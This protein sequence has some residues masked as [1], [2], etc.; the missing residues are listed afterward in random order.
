M[1]RKDR[2]GPLEGMAIWVKNFASKSGVQLASFCRWIGRL[3]EMSGQNE[4]VK[5][6]T[7]RLLENAGKYMYWKL[8][9]QW[10]SL[11]MSG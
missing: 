7:I 2:H 5:I 4:G 11:E 6:E 9:E 3:L 1:D 8:L 10:G